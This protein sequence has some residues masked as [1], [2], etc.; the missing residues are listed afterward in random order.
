MA[1]IRYCHGR[2]AANIK[3]ESLVWLKTILEDKINYCRSHGLKTVKP[4]R[5]E[6]PNSAMTPDTPMRLAS[7]GKIVTTVMALQCV[8]R[9]YLGLDDDVHKYLPELAQLQVLSGFDDSQRPLMRRPKRAITLG[10]LLSHT[11]GLIYIIEDES[12]LEKYKDLGSIPELIK[13][14]KDLGFIP[15]AGPKL[16]PHRYTYPLSYD[17]GT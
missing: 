1:P 11:S 8:E 6:S 9:G 4:D 16:V 17:R 3:I 12:M 14:Y 2:T 15:E 13:K 10:H 7:A 5:K